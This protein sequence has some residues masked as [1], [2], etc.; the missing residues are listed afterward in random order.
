MKPISNLGYLTESIF[1]KLN[2]EFVDRG[3]YYLIRTP[4]NPGFYWGNHLLF[5]DPPKVG[6]FDLWMN[7]HEREFGTD[8]QHIAFGW[9][10]DES[11]EISQFEEHGFSFVSTAV[12]NLNRLIRPEKFNHDL[13]VR[14]IETDEEWKEITE[15]QIESEYDG[16]DMVS[17]R[18]FKERQME[19]FRIIHDRKVGAWWGAFL[20]GVIVGYMGLFFDENK[21]IGRFQNVGTSPKFR[22]Q[23]V[24]STLLYEVCRNGIETTP[25]LIICAEK[26]GM[27]EGI[28][29]S[30]GFELC[31][32]QPGLSWVKSDLKAS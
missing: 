4:T 9:D 14:S 13:N 19:R 5:Q 2:G 30:L 32:L 22:R 25:N 23:G 12:L 31:S 24:C 16:S 18:S 3:D 1:H 28:Y 7:L 27:P 10:A 21:E 8:T 20:D 15:L 6:D 29:R 17:F 26:D 11:G